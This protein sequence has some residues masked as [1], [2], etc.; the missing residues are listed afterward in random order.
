L[1]HRLSLEYKN[2]STLKAE[3]Y[4]ELSGYDLVFLRQEKSSSNR[5]DDAQK[6]GLAVEWSPL[7]ALLITEAVSAEAKR[8]EFHFPTLFHQQALQRPR[9]SRAVNS[10]LSTTWQATAL[11]GLSGQW[12][13]KLSDYGFWYG[14]EYMKDVLAD[15]PY[16]RVDYYAITSKSVYYTV[17]MA[18]HFRPWDAVL[19]A[20]NVFTRARDRNY[21]AGNYILSNANGYSVKPYLSAAV[22]ISERVECDAHVSRT[23]VVGDDAQ[24]GYWDIRLQAMGGF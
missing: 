15:N 18:V 2:D 13:V 11:V 24:Q 16:A 19:T 21:S 10:S 20:G 5:T 22:S 14:R 7:S 8:G 17:D 12:S 4:G 9:Y 3:V 6:V 1:Q 23:F